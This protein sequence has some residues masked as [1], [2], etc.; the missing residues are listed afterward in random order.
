MK[1][2][3]WMEVGQLKSNKISFEELYISCQTNY[4][5]QNQLDL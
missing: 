5:K 1:A 2:N 3:H 4:E